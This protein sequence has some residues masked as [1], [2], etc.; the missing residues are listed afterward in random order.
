MW[1]LESGCGCRARYGPGTLIRGHYYPSSLAV[2]NTKRVEL[3]EGGWGVEAKEG[4]ARGW[5]R[6]AYL[7]VR[8]GTRRKVMMPLA[9]EEDAEGAKNSQEEDHG[10]RR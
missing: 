5:G 7:S 8:D 9:W 10:E 3:G 2:G 6:G 4:W 1:R